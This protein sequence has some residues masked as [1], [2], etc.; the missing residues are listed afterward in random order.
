MFV[1]VKDKSHVYGE[2]K[3]RPDVGRIVLRFVKS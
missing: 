2:I 3:P 1:K